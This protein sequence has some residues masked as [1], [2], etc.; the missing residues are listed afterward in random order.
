MNAIPHLTL[1]WTRD[2][3]T[4][5]L[6]SRTL[7]AI[8]IVLVLVLPWPIGA[9][10][11][12]CTGVCGDV[13]STGSMTAS[14]FVAVSSYISSA[15]SAGMDMECANVDD[16]AGVTLRDLVFMFWNLYTG[17]PL[18][19]QIDNGPFVPMN[20]PGY[21]LHYNSVFP[22]EDTAVML[23]IDATLGGPDVTW[24]V[25]VVVRVRTRLGSLNIT[26]PTVIYIFTLA[27]SQ[28]T[29]FGNTRVSAIHQAAPGPPVTKL[30]SVY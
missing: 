26:T 22:A 12:Q 7:L 23:N 8:A 21:H 24:A 27:R 20:N 28:N 16:H 2:L 9:A 6:A 25:S 10:H 29:A 14:D 3:R 15:D 19:C 11:A 18:D 4:T 17:F 5:F 13:D 1:S 30:A